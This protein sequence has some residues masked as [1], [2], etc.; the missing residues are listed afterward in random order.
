M[1]PTKYMRQLRPKEVKAQG[2]QA[3]P[4]GV[5]PGAEGPSVVAGPVPELKPGLLQ[6]LEELGTLSSRACVAD[7][8]EQG[9]LALVREKTR[10]AASSQ[11]PCPAS[12]LCLGVWFY[13]SVRRP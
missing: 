4:C 9:R 11:P 2:H 7:S 5:A 8:E 1:I 6:L 12:L 10:R 13:G 3:G